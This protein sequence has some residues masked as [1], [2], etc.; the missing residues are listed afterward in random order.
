MNEIQ[1]T[2]AWI[3]NFVVGLNICPFAGG[4]VEKEQ[5]RYLLSSAK[6]IDVLYQ[7]LLKEL[8]YLHETD[9]KEVETTVIVHPHV[10]SDFFLYLDFL[11]IANESLAEAGLEG[12]IQIASFH[13]DY[14]FEGEDPE[15]VSNYT[16]R[17][18]FPML[19]LIREA[20]VSKAVESHPD[21]EG[22]P[23]R[24]IDLLREMG[25]EKVKALVGLSES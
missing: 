3:R 14:H 20:S 23:Q 9:P 2:E 25:L 12:E 8:L 6:D 5:V 10:L 18:P 19:H 15:D 16:N 21:I 7:D 1:K 13:P 17:S 4:A 11:E 22:V 24:N